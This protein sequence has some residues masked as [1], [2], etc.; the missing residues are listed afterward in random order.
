MTKLPRSCNDGAGEA[1]ERPVW[2][3]VLKWV[4]V[5]VCIAV[6]VCVLPLGILMLCAWV[7]WWFYG[8][9]ILHLVR[10]VRVIGKV[11]GNEELSD[12]DNDPA[13][14]AIV[15]YTFDGVRYT[16]HDG[17]QAYRRWPL[18]NAV[19]I[20]HIPGSG[21]PGRHVPLG[22]LL[23]FLPLLLVVSLVAVA[24][25]LGLAGAIPMKLWE[26]LTGKGAA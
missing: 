13:Y 22:A 19:R 3:T 5:S 15:E 1:D 26:L 20:Y 9:N 14:R 8:S 6:G 16:T 4:A 10:G 21:K 11:A 7:M 17:P 23:V 2:L 12:S 24:F 25:A 18:G